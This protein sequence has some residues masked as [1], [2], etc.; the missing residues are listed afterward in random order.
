MRGMCTMLQVGQ[1]VGNYKIVG[2]IAQGSYANV[3]KATHSVLT[4]RV[5]A[6]KI[7]LKAFAGT[8][9]EANNILYQEAQIL[10][11]LQHPY[12][13]ALIDFGTY[14][15][16]P[17]IV[18]E[19]APNGSLRDRLRKLR[20]QAIPY[21]EGITILHQVGEAL[22]FA[23]QAHVIHCD[24]KPENILF[25][26]Q[27]AALVAD[28][29]IARVTKTA[30]SSVASLGGT[31]SYMAPEQFHGKV[32]NE[33]DQYS[34]ACMAYEMLTGR[35][36]FQGQSTDELRNAHFHEV[37]V[38]PTQVNPHLPLH[39]D[40]ALL[41]A[42]EKD[43]KARF[44]SI[45]AFI[46]ALDPVQSPIATQPWPNLVNPANTGH[47]Q[48][49]ILR[50]RGTAKAEFGDNI[51]YEETI[52]MGPDDGVEKAAPRVR[53][54]PATHVATVE[55]KPRTTTAKTPTSSKTKTTASKSTTANKPGAATTSKPPTASK[56]RTSKATTAA[57]INKP[58]TA[59]A[60]TTATDS[61]PK[62][63]TRKA[64]PARAA[65]DKKPAVKKS[66]PMEKAPV[67]R[68]KPAKTTKPA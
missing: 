47:S 3:Y 31:P 36:P 48:H 24:L 56:T 4:S 33:S 37:P 6:L 61:K 45:S 39:I 55:H 38:P 53:K 9:G 63:A 58:K 26:A 22:Q 27:H 35:R 10:E 15:N 2:E 8:E 7:L 62:P 59:K 5:V 32:Y 13:L 42:L 46:E 14:E 25:N 23:H 60:A 41:R 11:R 1:Q 65:T 16:Y 54:T 17:Y 21:N 40:Q 68:K 49:L 57:T 12:I 18:K 52:A 34:L 29:D 19:Y 64:V 67:A 50:A 20:G 30:R 43:V 66:T 51:F 28:F 44:A